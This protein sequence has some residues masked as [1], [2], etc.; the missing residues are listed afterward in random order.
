MT[1]K[2]RNNIIMYFLSVKEKQSCHALVIHGITI[3]QL[4]CQ[5][6]CKHKEGTMCPAL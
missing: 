5:F 3:I 6:Q 4:N 1:L 2:H